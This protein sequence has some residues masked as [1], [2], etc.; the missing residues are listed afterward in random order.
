MANNKGGTGA[1][2]A[3]DVMQPGK[4]V[5]PTT[6]RPIIVSNRPM[7]R[8]DPMMV[9]PEGMEKP[10]AQPAQQ[11]VSRVG[12]TLTVLA[13]HQSKTAKAPAV[14]PLIPTD[15][16]DNADA[17]SSVAV[18]EPA[19]SAIPQGRTPAE[20]ASKKSITVKTDEAVPD[21]VV[22]ATSTPMQPKTLAAPASEPTVEVSKPIESQD[23]DQTVSKPAPPVAESAPSPALAQAP[24]ASAPAPA[25]APSTTEEDI[26][27][28]TESDTDGPRPDG[29]DGQLAPNKT[30]DDAKK[31]VDEAEAARDAEQEQI[32]N[33][34]R[35][36]LPI[37]N[38][39]DRRGLMRSL[40]VL[41][42]VV[43]LAAVWFDMVLDAGIVHVGN[44]HA[45]THFFH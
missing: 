10:E 15:K 1:P 32:I 6:S 21:S 43:V 36:Y 29:A 13:P 33:S 31:K 40:L 9:S 20:I 12:K 17:A 44:L 23:I 25:A 4:A 45:L 16:I 18:D 19:A 38:T 26:S 42:I 30:I 37:A 11:T 24:V 34:K 28:D 7:L 3:M 39:E 35:Y 27:V 5:P 41:L 14:M 22:P 2:K 8:Q